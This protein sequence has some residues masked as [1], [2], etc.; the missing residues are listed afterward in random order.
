V[1]NCVLV[2]VPATGF[3]L[4]AA[5]RAAYD[6]MALVDV[7]FSANEQTLS[8]ALSPARPDVDMT[9]AERDFRRALLDHELRQSIEQQ[10]DPLRTAILA[11]AFSKTG[12]QG[13]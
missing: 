8:C 1:K 5:K 12:L 13:E 11:L 10:T 2:E 3:S 7:S 6:L 9:S 4:G